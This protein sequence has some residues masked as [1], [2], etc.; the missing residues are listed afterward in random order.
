[1]ENKTVQ[2]DVKENVIQD[3]EVV[4]VEAKEAK[5]KTIFIWVAVL[6]L[7]CLQAG[8]FW[9]WDQQKSQN[10]DLKQQFSTAMV[11]VSESSKFNQSLQNANAAI[12]K[13]V[14]DLDS[15]QQ[16]LLEN[17]EALS[18]SQQI[19]RG[20]VEQYWALAEVEYLLNIANQRVLLA[21]DALG[22]SNALEMADA[23]IEALSDYRLH[24]LRALLAD[25]LLA[26]SSVVKVDGDGMALQLQTALDNVDSLQVLMAPAVTEG[27]EDSEST[28]ED[29]QGALD[30]AWQEV[31]SLVVI[32]HQQ[33]GAAAA[34]LV[35]EQRYFLYQNLKLKLETARLA[36]LAGESS[37]LESS[38]KS[39]AQWLEQYFT[40]EERDAMLALVTE[41]QAINTNISLPDI[42]ASLSWLKGFER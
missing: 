16:S 37:V 30:Q 12:K 19:T 27:E 15:K 40:G 39:S 31:K 2:Q 11:S 3:A 14:T 33:D 20:D 22:A 25:E 1:M 8:S 24:P 36:L 32:R 18:A 13:E 28:S 4:S 23:R 17:I 26:L 34:V 29:W 6:L 42:S 7:L 9:L 10:E 38:L 5:P 21:N 41:L 35:P